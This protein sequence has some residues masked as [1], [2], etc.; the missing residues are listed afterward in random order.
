V[1]NVGKI[2]FFFLVKGQENGRKRVI[3]QLVELEGR[4][5]LAGFLRHL[6]GEFSIEGEPLRRICDDFFDFEFVISA[7]ILVVG[8]E[9]DEEPYVSFEDF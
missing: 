3:K 7:G 9:D 2:A 5:I 8:I 4:K 1:N 6:G